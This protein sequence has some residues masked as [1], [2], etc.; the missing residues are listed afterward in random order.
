M[1]KQK[2]P[3]PE[4][5]PEQASQAQGI[6]SLEI[7]VSLLKALAQNDGPMSLSAL[8][9]AA[10]MPASSCRRYLLSLIR[11]GLVQQQV[12]SGKYDLGGG[13]LK[14]GLQALSRSDIVGAAIDRALLLRDETK[15]TTVVSVFGERGPTVIGWFD[16]TPRL[17]V[18][19]HLGSV[20]SLL[21]TATGR[22]FLA[23]L[24]PADIE[25]LL[26]AELKLGTSARASASIKVIVAEVRGAMHSMIRDEVVPGL[27]AIAAPVFNA[28]G[29]IAS[30]VTIITRSVDMQGQRSTA[31]AMAVQKAASEVSQAAGFVAAE[32][33]RSLAHWLAENWRTP[34]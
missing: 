33:K 31:L 21:G 24:P 9:Q 12:R 22:V 29:S 3:H 4:T 11:A 23:F 19:S 14:L 1:P 15:Q 28:Q 13:L 10:D 25:P 26:R 2:A 18:N 8:A 6:Q 5:P 16:G 30:V 17:I 34:P 7:G 20:Y 27:G 32:R